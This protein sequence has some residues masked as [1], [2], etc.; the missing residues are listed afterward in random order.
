MNTEFAKFQSETAGSVSASTPHPA[1][2]VRILVVEDDPL[3]QE[4]MLGQLRQLG[5]EAEIASDAPAA[6][7]NWQKQPFDLVLLTCDSPGI[8]VFEV[9]GTI[10]RFEAESNGYPRGRCSIVAVTS[11]HS[12][13]LRKRY[14]SASMNA[15]LERP[16]D[17]GRLAM[18]LQLAAHGND[19]RARVAAPAPPTR[20]DTAWFS[21]GAQLATA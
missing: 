12:I 8:D 15:C 9:A 6:L 14:L 21:R 10:R 13:N 20:W 19:R 18:V 4:M 5:F 17:P 16:V 7:S 11:S 1:S 2:R 3:S